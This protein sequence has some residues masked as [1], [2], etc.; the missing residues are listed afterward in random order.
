MSLPAQVNGQTRSI[1]VARPAHP[2]SQLHLEATAANLGLFIDLCRA[3]KCE[4]HRRYKTRGKGPPV[5]SMGGNRQARI[6]L[7]PASN[8]KRYRYEK[9]RT[10]EAPAE[11]EPLP[12]DEHEQ[13]LHDEYEEEFASE[14][15]SASSDDEQ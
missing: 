2:E 13:E 6:E 15:G 9:P 7:S 11:A 4:G 14:H 12:Q 5:V 1:N 8:K 3:S 10:D